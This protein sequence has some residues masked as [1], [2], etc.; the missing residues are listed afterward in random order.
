[1]QI[2]RTPFI[3]VAA[4]TALFALT[5][6]PVGQPDTGVGVSMEMA[7]GSSARD[8]HLTVDALDA[9][10]TEVVFD[11]EGPE[12]SISV[13]AE[14]DSQVDVTTGVANPDIVAIELT[15][16]TYE[17]VNLGVEIRDEDAQPGI[18]LEGELDGQAIRLEFNSGEVFE[19]EADL[20]EVP[21]DEIV[22]VQFILDP[23]AWFS[24]VDGTALQV[25]DDGVALIS[26][27][28]NAGVF[29]TI[30][31]LLDESTESVFPGG[32][33]GD[34]DDDDDDAR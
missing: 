2:K 33:M 13:T 14:Q 31:D 4:S 10:V 27:T 6:C 20:L 15:G 22:Q 7:S 12:G 1:M 11:A 32:S 18:V 34:D 26:E 30:A 23:Q 28:S 19:A 17:S 5:G 29:D 21:A 3:V 8:N 24:G 25:G 9:W 16:G